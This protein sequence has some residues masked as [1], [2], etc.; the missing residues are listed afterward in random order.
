MG[1]I[2]KHLKKAHPHYRIGLAELRDLF[3]TLNGKLATEVKA[4]CKDGMHLLGQL[5]LAIATDN[6][7]P[8][9]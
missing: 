7:F 9:A 6:R 1:R 5:P 2:I 4:E 8:L 3:R